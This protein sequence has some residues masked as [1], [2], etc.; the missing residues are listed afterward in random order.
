MWL[1]L[2][3]RRQIACF[4]QGLDQRRVTG[5]RLRKLLDGSQLEGDARLV[6]YFR[7]NTR[8][9]L[10]TLY[11]SDFRVAMEKAGAETPMEDF[12]L[13]L[14]PELPPLGRMIALDQ[15]FFLADHNLTYTDKMSMAC[16]VEV[17]VPFL[18]LDMVEFAQTIS[19]EL[20]QRGA[21]GKWILKKA[22]EPYLPRDI[23]YRQK[24]GFGAPLRR[25]LRSELREMLGNVLSEKSLTQRGIFDPVAVRRLIEANDAGRADASFTLFSL[26]CMELWF[27]RFIDLGEQRSLAAH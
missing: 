12:L 8:E 6:N 25:W 18:D 17:R 10:K 22:M 3:L 1:P 4:A 21:E 26:M 9:D 20:K 19:L 7:W 24:T 14:P 13:Q 27:R 5:R 15:R 16:G 11:S 2:S 23:I